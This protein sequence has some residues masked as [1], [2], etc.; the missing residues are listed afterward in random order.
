MSATGYTGNP[1]GSG[2]GGGG[3]VAI[4]DVTG[5]TAVLAGKVNDT[6]DTISGQLTVD[7]ILKVG[8]SVTLEI[9]ADTN[10]YR[11]GANVLA[12]DDALNIGGNLLVYG[13]ADF[14]GSVTGVDKTD[15]GLANVDNTADT[16]KPVS[17]SQQNA[18]DLKANLAG[19]ALTGNPTAPTQTAG[20]NTTRLA[21]TAFVTTAVAA[22]GGGGGGSSLAVKNVIDSTTGYIVPQAAAAWAS[23]TG[24]PTISMAAA[25]N[26]YVSL[27]VLG[28]LLKTTSSTF[29]EL[30][31]MVG[32]VPVR[33]ASTGTATPSV[34][35]D[36]AFYSDFNFRTPGLGFALKV[37]SGDLSG[38]TI[39]FG[40]A[41]KG[42]GTGTTIYAGADY[43]LRWRIMNYG[44]VTVS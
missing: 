37:A 21:T 15:V 12:T 22:S 13:G 5:L 8:T 29:L 44:A 19:P 1:P 20:N 17:T 18:L 27:E 16:A 25:V 3:S 36:P 24:G 14:Q 10:L 40:W 31:I 43:P 38:G 33:Y 11:A 4:S 7:G 42:V 34:E 6:G 9:G 35:G 26:D 2:G 23:V 30:A 41:V 32:G 28:M 39:T